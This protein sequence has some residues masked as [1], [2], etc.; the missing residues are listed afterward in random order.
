MTKE[1]GQTKPRPT[2]KQQNPVDAVLD[3]LIERHPHLTAARDAM[4]R[5]GVVCNQFSQD[6]LSVFRQK[7]R[8]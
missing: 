7:F 3:E 1:K 6:A 8:V 2:A 4:R 5:D